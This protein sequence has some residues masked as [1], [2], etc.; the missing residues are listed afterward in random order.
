MCIYSLSIIVDLSFQI[1][2]IVS[3]MLED[4]IFGPAFS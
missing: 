3:I 4:L 2:G 1:P